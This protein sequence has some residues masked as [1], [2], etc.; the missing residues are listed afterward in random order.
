MK[1]ASP[2]L[3]AHRGYAA[4]WPENSLSA[5]DAAAA[6]GAQ[7]VE[8]DVQLCADEVPVLL[9]DVE[10]ERLT[11]R[12]LSLS[13]LTAAA[14]AG[15]PLCEPGR[16]GTRFADE[17]VMTLAE[18]ANWYAGQPGLEAFVEV[19]PQ[20]I[21]RFGREAVVQACLSA[22]SAAKRAWVPISWDYE[23]LAL[24]ADSGVE[25]VGWVVRDWDEAVAALARKLPARWLFCNH[26]RLPPGPLPQGAWEWVI[27]EVAAAPLAMELIGR[28]ARWLETMA[29]KELHQAIEQAR[30]TVPG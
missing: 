17:R 6:A 7:W 30:S 29:I 28:G 23:V 18:F 5:L 21:E 2:I 25:P 9:H 3:V 14:L 4:H 20:S 19:K 12:A 8:V 11:G 10:L 24:F 27:Y 16:F 22:M 15:V 26:L 1:N 13:G